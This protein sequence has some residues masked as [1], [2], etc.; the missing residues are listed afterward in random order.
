MWHIRAC[1]A[2]S[3]ARDYQV[4]LNR[5]NC[6]PQFIVNVLQKTLRIYD[7]IHLAIFNCKRGGPDFIDGIVVIPDWTYNTKRYVPWVNDAAPTA[8]V[9]TLQG[10][11]VS[12]DTAVSSDVSTLQD[13]SKDS[14]NNNE[15]KKSCHRVRFESNEMSGISNINPDIASD[16][17]KNAIANSESNIIM[18]TGIIIE[19]NDAVNS[20]A[21]IHDDRVDKS[22]DTEIK[23]T[24]DNREGNKYES[25]DK[26]SDTSDDV[27]EKASH[28][29]GISSNKKKRTREEYEEIM[30]DV[31]VYIIISGI[32]NH[33]KVGFNSQTMAKFKSRYHTYIGEFDFLKFSFPYDESNIDD[34]K[35]AIEIARFIELAFKAA[36]AENKAYEGN[37]VELYRKEEEGKDMLSVYKKTLSKIIRQYYSKVR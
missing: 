26:K 32:S 14:L 19:G 1:I 6:N 11:T 3:N 34:R 12:A 35:R 37:N 21:S 5:R 29:L 20:H 24:Q 8:V 22:D 2:K 16:T 30:L 10:A 18:N 33:Y 31:F 28:F 4:F 23:I 9:S 17:T 15:S 7:Q 36:E 25:N 27:E 13:G